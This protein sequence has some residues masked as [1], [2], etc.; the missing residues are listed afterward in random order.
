MGKAKA[1]AIRNRV[2]ELRMV[3]AAELV[4]NEKN[5]RRH[6]P[7]QAAALKGLLDEIGYADALIA[8]ELP[9]GKLKLIDGHL[10]RETTPD[11]TVPV[12]V[13]DLTEEEAD[14]LLLTL[15]PLAAMATANQAAVEKLLETVRTDSKAVEALLERVAG[16]SAW[17]AVNEQAEAGE[18][19]QLRESF[20]ILV[21]CADEAQQAELLQRFIAEGLKCRA[22][23][24]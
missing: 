4:P 15:D 16:E 3:R 9:D 13:L 2:K 19:S 6:P 20:N 8:R 14:K 23:I 7:E 18:Q 17:Q 5:W 22:L 21:E 24:S 11:A 1:A 10:R 12:L